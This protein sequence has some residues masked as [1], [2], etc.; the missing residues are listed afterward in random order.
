MLIIVASKPFFSSLNI[1]ME[2][3][4]DNSIVNNRKI[5]REIYD[6]V[7]GKIDEPNR[8]FKEVNDHED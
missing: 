2:S 5:Y 3:M 8:Y 6:R 4:D 1:K 7:I